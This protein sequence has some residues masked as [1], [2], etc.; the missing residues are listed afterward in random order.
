MERPAPFAKG[1]RPVCSSSPDRRDEDSR[2]R[3]QAQASWLTNGSSTS[4][5]PPDWHLEGALKYLGLIVL[6]APRVAPIA[7]EVAR[8]IALA[9]ASMRRVGPWS[10]SPGTPYFQVLGPNEIAS[11]MGIGRGA[12]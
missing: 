9:L 12:P 1:R 5:L 3:A 8:E 7:Y 6:E 10:P 11:L 4:H 2:H